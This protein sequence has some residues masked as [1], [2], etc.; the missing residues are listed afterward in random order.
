MNRRTQGSPKT[1]SLPGRNQ[2]LRQGYR[3]SPPCASREKTAPWPRGAA[4]YRVC[5]RSPVHDGCEYRNELNCLQ[6][7]DDT[8]LGGRCR[9]FGRN[10][11]CCFT[12]RRRRLKWLSG[13]WNSGNMPAEIRSRRTCT[14][15][16]RWCEGFRQCASKRWWRCVLRY[17]AVRTTTSTSSNRRS[18]GWATTL[19]FCVVGS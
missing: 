8:D 16:W 18:L 9:R 3:S 12:S 15:G 7:R 19:A 13:G 17:A 11:R 4:A 5:P 10:N 6:R 2:N 1:V 14:G